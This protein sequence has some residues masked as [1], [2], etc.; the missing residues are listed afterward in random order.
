MINSHSVAIYC[1]A[2]E[3]ST[4][5]SNLSAQACGDYSPKHA[6]TENEIALTPHMLNPNA[7]MMISHSCD[8]E[9]IA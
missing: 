3:R 4:L 9:G 8:A 5:L 2:K 6:I 7:G 1:G